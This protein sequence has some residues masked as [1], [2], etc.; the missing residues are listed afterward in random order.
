[1]APYIPEIAETAVND[2]N[3][4]VERLRKNYETGTAFPVEY[5]KVQLRRLFW[6]IK[7]NE[8]LIL[9]ALKQDIG[10]P[11]LEAWISEIGMIL[12]E[13]QLLLD[14][15]DRLAGGE[16]AVVKLQY[17]ALMP[18][19]RKDPLGIVLI[20]GAYNYPFQ[21]IFS[22]LIG[23]IAAGNAVVVKC[24]EA[25]PA[26]CYVTQKIFADALDPDLY[27]TVHGGI[28]LS[29][30]LLAQKWDLIFYTGNSTVARI[31][32]QAA[33]KNLTPTVLELGGINPVVV[34][35]S[36]DVKLA[37]RRITWGKTHNAGQICLSPSY[38]VC[39]S[40]HVDALI[41]GIKDTLQ[42]FYPNGVKAS[43]DYGRIVNN[44]HFHRIKKM[45]ESS[46]GEIVVGGEF[47]ESQNFISPTFVR[48]SDR[49]DPLIAEEIFGPACA[50]LV[51]DDF[52]SIPRLVRDIG[53]TPLGAYIFSNDANEVKTFM[54]NTRSGGVTINDVVLHGGVGNVPFGGVGESGNGRYRG[55]YSFDVFSNQ[56]A[57]VKTPGWIDGLLNIRYPPYTRGKLSKIKGQVGAPT[58]DRNG[59]EF[60][61]GRIWKTLF[62]G[63]KTPKK[64]VVRYFLV[65]L[66]AYLA[67]KR[68]VN[69]WPILAT[70]PV[71][72]KFLTR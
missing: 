45:I 36:A 72:G 19:V 58:F 25:T 30:E 32:Q 40:T 35:K 13:I 2:V 60:Y 24:S 44:R 62:L 14:N 21:L 43:P 61:P 28:P 46:N 39:H 17:K 63:A 11:C 52:Q 69:S 49:H 53:D 71:I 16:K 7:D 41:Q 23:A 29:T 26:T 55:L 51:V 70:L 3:A 5:R 18:H 50:I 64:A 22:P 67:R 12:E 65:L 59:R 33:A 68:L 9:E 54:Q 47:D 48:I 15:I 27:T 56:R 6:A 42:E 57:V 38:I 34:T 31:V 66:T 8:E 1:M 4:I 10:K 20:M 37:A